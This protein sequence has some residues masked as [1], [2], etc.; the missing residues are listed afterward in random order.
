MNELETMHL[1]Q[2]EKDRQELEEVIKKRRRDAII[3]FMLGGLTGALI[4]LLFL[5]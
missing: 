4:Y 1:A 5:C 3:S 2:A